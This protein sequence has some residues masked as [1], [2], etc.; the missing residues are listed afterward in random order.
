MPLAPLSRRSPRRRP[1][2]ATFR[3]LA[4]I[5]RCPA[6]PLLA[7]RREKGAWPCR[8]H[9]PNNSME[10]DMIP[11]PQ[12]AP[13]CRRALAN[14]TEALPFAPRRAQARENHTFCRGGHPVVSSV[15]LLTQ[16][17]KPAQ[18]LGYV[19]QRIQPLAQEESACSSRGPRREKGVT[20]GGDLCQIRHLE[21]HSTLL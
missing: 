13:G 10:K 7:N 1:P 9:P 12:E 4:S 16:T 15:P 8:P 2:G 14:D 21:K 5:K 17:A 3:T 11:R 18:L 20:P 6:W 19:S